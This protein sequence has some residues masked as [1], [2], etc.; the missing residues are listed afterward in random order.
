MKIDEPREH[1]WELAPSSWDVFYALVFV[2][3]VVVA[4]WT[5][6]STPA[7]I[8]LSVTLAGVLSGAH[9]DTTTMTTNTTA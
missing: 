2:V 3:I 7:R 9:S 5:R 1:A 4:E 8:T 6:L